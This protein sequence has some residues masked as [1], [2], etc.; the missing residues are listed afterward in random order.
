MARVVD[1]K[2]FDSSI[3]GSFDDLAAMR[4]TRP[5]PRAD[6]HG[7]PQLA[8][9][10]RSRS[11]RGEALLLDS[12]LSGL[13]AA[14]SALEAY[15]HDGTGDAS[16]ARR[17]RSCAS[18]AE[19]LVSPTSP[20]AYVDGPSI[21]AERAE[22]AFPAPGSPGARGAALPPVDGRKRAS[23]AVPS[24]LPPSDPPP[25]SDAPALRSPTREERKKLHRNELV[26]RFLSLDENGDGEVTADEFAHAMS[27]AVWTSNLQPDFNLRVIER[28]GPS[29]STV[30]REVDESHRFVQTSAESTSIRPSSRVDCPKPV[31]DFHAGPRT[32]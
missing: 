9:L 6:G 25:A 5:S 2:S 13:E 28:F 19:A 32:G 14:V 26:E 15:G 3:G 4:P 23:Y 11:G 16:R 31:V 21:G 17:L 8:P 7:A 24:A 22:P 30:L 18:R 29:P 10:P 12:L 20:R 1:V 27:R